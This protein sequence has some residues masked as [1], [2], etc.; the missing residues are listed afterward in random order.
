[1]IIIY[2]IEQLAENFNKLSNSIDNNKLEI[3]LTNEQANFF[4][5][6]IVNDYDALRLKFKEYG[7]YI[8]LWVNDVSYLKIDSNKPNNKSIVTLDFDI[9]YNRLS[10][11][12]KSEYF[13]HSKIGNYLVK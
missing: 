8:E 6:L 9:I 4:N 7:L 13:K 3:K 2:I 5:Y 12:S 11:H 10:E 1:M